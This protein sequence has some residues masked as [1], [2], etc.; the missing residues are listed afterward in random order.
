MQFVIVQSA[1]ADYFYCDGQSFV[2]G[3]ILGVSLQ[4]KYV[5]PQTLPAVCLEENQLGMAR[6]LNV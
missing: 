2:T 1:P 4:V 3:L 5:I 6:S